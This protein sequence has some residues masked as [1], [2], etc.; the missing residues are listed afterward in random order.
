MEPRQLELGYNELPIVCN[1]N[2][3]SLDILFQSLIVGS[4][5][6]TTSRGSDSNAHS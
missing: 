3:F 4:L 1:S 5:Q 6:S 2:Y